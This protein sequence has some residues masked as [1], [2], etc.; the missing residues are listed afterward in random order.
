MQLNP[1]WLEPTWFIDSGN[2]AVMHFA[3][4]AAGEATDPVEV[5]GKLFHAVRDGFRYDPY[6]TQA[7]PRSFRA[8]TVAVSDRN[9]CIP[10]SV[11]FVAAARHRG[12]PARLGLRT[13]VITSRVRSCRSP[14]VRTCLRGMGMPNYYSTVAG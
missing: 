9:W 4:A 5:A 2:E 10:K 1:K 12:I 14:W 3:D 13:C 11:L 6:V 8:S 7:D